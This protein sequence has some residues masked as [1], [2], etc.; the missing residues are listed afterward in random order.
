[1]SSN[2]FDLKKNVKHGAGKTT[3]QIQNI[4][5]TSNIDF[6]KHYI[7]RM[8][9]KKNKVNFSIIFQEIS[10]FLKSYFLREVG[11]VAPW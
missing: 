6:S 3:K 4:A 8:L 1:M 9:W 11:V 2:T 5:V 7:A 10:N